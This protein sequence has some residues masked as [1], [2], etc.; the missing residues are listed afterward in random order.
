[1]KNDCI[2]ISIND[3][4]KS[5]P[6]VAY[7]SVQDEFF[8]VWASAPGE[9]SQ[10]AD[11]FVSGQIISVKGEKLGETID[12]FK[13]E[14]IVMLPRVLYNPNK[15]QYLV[16]YCLGLNYFNIHGVIL[17]EKGR[18]V[19]EHFRVVDAPA[20][21]FHYTMAFN[22]TKGQYLVTYND[23][24]NEISNAYGVILDDCGKVIKEEFVI[25]DAVGHQ[26]NPVVCY[27]PKDDTYLINWEDFRA[28]G[29]SLEALETL[30]VMTDIFGALLS[31]DGTILANNIPM[32]FDADGINADQRFN[33]IAYN[34]KN[35]Q[36]LSSW[37]DTR[38]SLQNTGVVGRI[39]N[40]DGSMPE[41]DFLLVDAPGA[42][43]ISHAVYVPE[44]D[45]YFIAFERDLNELDNFYFKDITANLD[46]AAMWLDAEGRPEPDIIDIFKGEGN[47]RFVRFAYSAQ[48]KTF[49]LVWQSD[50]PGV[51]DSAEGHIMSAGGNI[52]GKIYKQ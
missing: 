46:I 24:R 41:E 39:V 50:F 13:T 1:M 9:K 15:N 33:G 48:S 2:E 43:M 31:S 16:I 27:N 36:F 21:Q 40:S 19:G 25:S 38:D 32:C 28:H 23:F 20:N 3:H 6:D 35:N 17:D 47:H 49:L 5:L 7:N 29:D 14:D 10:T 30:E 34:S 8:T 37:T 4:R 42:Q 22:S 11:Y 12:V 44:E 51:S 52:M 18:A 26:V 45:K